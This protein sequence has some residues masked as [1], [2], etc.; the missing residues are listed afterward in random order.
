MASVKPAVE[1][2]IEEI[3]LLERS[4]EKD[5]DRLIIQLRS[6]SDSE[7]IIA[8]RE[9]NFFQELIDQGYGKA[10]DNFDSNYTE[11]L[12]ASLTEA[13]RRGVPA[14]AGASVE[15]LETLRDLEYTRLLGRA[16]TYADELKN[17]LFRG[18]YG[19]SSIAEITNS[20]RNTGLATHQLN[21]IAYDG[22]KIFD[23]M[24]RYKVFE[25]SDVRWTYVG[26]QDSQTRDECR[27]T[28]DNEPSKGYTEEEVNS[29]DTPFGVRGGF[30][31][32]HSWEVK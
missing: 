17:N 7:L 10:L 26:P 2:F 5:L 12:N 32:R 14:L 15:G 22:I 23:D 28:K 25:G 8:T 16:R 4:F 29:S 18:I 21:V 31:C 13:R 6:M 19:N 20:I 27:A 9:L 24:S 30:N 11:L 1:D 3:T